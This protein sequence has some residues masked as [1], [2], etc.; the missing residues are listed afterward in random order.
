VGWVLGIIGFFVFLV[1]LCAVIYGLTSV[2]N[3]QTNAPIP[4]IR[5]PNT[6]I[7][8][9]VPTKTPNPTPTPTP[10]I[11]VVSVDPQ[12]LLLTKAD[13]PKDAGYYIPGPDWMS[14]HYNFEVI[15]QFGVDRGQKYVDRT[16]RIMG[17]W[18]NFN[19]G[20]TKII[21]PQEIYDNVILFKTHE[22]AIIYLK[23]YT[24]CD[25]PTYK[26]TVVETTLLLGDASQ[27]CI[28]NELQPSGDNRTT[29]EI[30]F[31]YRNIAHQV[32][33]WGWEREVGHDYVYSVAETLLSRLKTIP[34]S[35]QVTF[36]P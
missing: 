15:A 8:T 5:P 23:E 26:Y 24:T 27:V 2:T 16:G 30:A 4:T 12:T 29:F 31:V 36:T 6:Q 25:D 11:R 18:V 1:I 3:N 14:P 21:T 17:W 22:G 19:R 9:Q 28:L 20:S 33:G 34:L 32:A 7:P 13:L 10:D 35:E